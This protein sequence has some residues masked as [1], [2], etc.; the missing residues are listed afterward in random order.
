MKLE[1]EWKILLKVEIQEFIRQNTHTKPEEI[2]FKKHKFPDWPLN[3]M[4][5][6][7]QCLQKA[8]TKLPTWFKTEN[9]LY[10]KL[11]LEQ[12]SSELTAQLKAEILGENSILIDLSG[13]F[14]VDTYFFAQKNEK[15][16]HIEPNEFLQ[17]LV[18]HNCNC[19]KVKNIDFINATAE[20]FPIQN[21]PSAV[22]FVDPSRR[23][24]NKNRVFRLED[25]VPDLE[26]ILPKIKCQQGKILIKTS[27]LLD[28]SLTIKTLENVKE[29]WVIAIQNEV[30]EVLYLIDYQVVTKE[31]EVH[32]FNYAKQNHWQGFNFSFAEEMQAKLDVKYSEPMTYLY[33]PNASIMKA[34]AFYS[35]AQQYRLHKLHPNSHLYTSEKLLANMPARVFVLQ[36]IIKLDKKLIHKLLPDKKANIAVRNFP[37]TVAE[38]RQKIQIKEGG[39][40]YIFFTTDLNNQLIGLLTRKI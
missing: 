1:N 2:L 26:I 8:Q 18:E 9:I 16:I 7:I 6:Q 36:E 11:A 39:E 12:C 22:F 10:Q 35:F 4:V 38:I 32:T 27:P 15:V 17:N 25:C 19:L 24:E 20:D 33:E 23:D 5:E 37:L 28:I 3:G 40:A 30:K 31:I 13:G 21:Y 29:V 34:G 14:G